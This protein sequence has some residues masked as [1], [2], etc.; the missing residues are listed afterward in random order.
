M[1]ALPNSVAN[2]AQT[3]DIFSNNAPLVQSEAQLGLARLS[4]LVVT[5][6]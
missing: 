1:I 6:N 5:K 3:E 4:G 2:L